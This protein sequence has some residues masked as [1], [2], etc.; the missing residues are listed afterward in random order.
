M[1]SCVFTRRYVGDSATLA[2]GLPL[3]RSLGLGLGKGLGKGLGMRQG[4]RQKGL[5]RSLFL[6][7]S[8]VDHLSKGQG[9]AQVTALE[10]IT[11]VIPSPWAIRATVSMDTDTGGPGQG[12]ALVVVMALALA[13]AM[14]V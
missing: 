4:M 6:S 7:R 2:R 3:A 10:L 8:A 11:T 13:L 5:T 9:G 1:I 14:A 12:Q